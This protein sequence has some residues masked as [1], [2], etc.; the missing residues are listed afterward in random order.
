MPDSSIVSQYFS[1]D[2]ADT[3]RA[4]NKDRLCRKN[5]DGS[6][7]KV[8]PKYSGRINIEKDPNRDAWKEKGEKPSWK[9]TKTEE[10][11][12]I[13]AKVTVDQVSD[14]VHRLKWWKKQRSKF[15]YSRKLR[16]CQHLQNN[17]KQR[18]NRTKPEPVVENPPTTPGSCPPG[19]YLEKW[20]EGERKG[21]AWQAAN[22]FREKATAE[23][24]P[25]DTYQDWCGSSGQ[26]NGQGHTKKQENSQ[27]LPPPKRRRIGANPFEDEME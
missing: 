8:L 15:L 12:E 9:K 4:L 6:D 23:Y 14:L 22:P 27:G 10:Y 5:P 13:D 17:R 18:K 20:A 25:E 2:F 19:S 1:R 16:Q 26:E 3:E 7:G 21:L 11:L 24:G